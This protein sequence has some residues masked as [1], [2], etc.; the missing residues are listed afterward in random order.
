MSTPLASMLLKY[1]QPCHICLK[2]SHLL[3]YF[4]DLHQLQDEPRNSCADSHCISSALGTVMIVHDVSTDERCTHLHSKTI[5][6]QP[7]K[8]YASV[9][10][11]LKDVAIGMMIVMMMIVMMMM[12]MMMMMLVMMIVIVMMIVMMMMIVISLMMMIVVMLVMMLMVIMIVMMKHI[13][14]IRFNHLSNHTWCN[15]YAIYSGR[16]GS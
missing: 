9:A 6:G 14:M 10:I 5:H 4:D 3:F 1:L 15:R 2:P 7:I 11:D 8:F 13:C 16:G 12:M